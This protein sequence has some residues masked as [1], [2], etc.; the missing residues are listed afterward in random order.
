[1]T[2][3]TP[4][5]RLT[6]RLV[7]AASWLVCR[8]PG[9]AVD[10]VADALGALHHLIAPRPQRAL[11]RANLQ[12]VCTALV[13]DGLASPRVRS[14]ATDPRA[15][16][17]MVRSVYR[18]HARYLAELMRGPTMTAS[19][20]AEHLTLESPEEIDAAYARA[21]AG[22][23][24]LVLG[25][26]LGPV[27][28]PAIYSAARTGRRVVGPMEAIANPPLQAWFTRQRSR[29][30]VD[31]L[32]P[33]ETAGPEL[34]R[35][36]HA[37][38]LVGIVADRDITGSGRPTPFFGAPAPLAAGPALLALES[39]VPTYAASVRRTGWGRYAGRM[40]PLE[41]P[42]TGTRRE[43]MSAFMLGEARVFE[44]L[45]ADAPDQW[46]SLLFPIWPDLTP[47]DAPGDARPVAAGP[48]RWLRP[49]PVSRRTP[50]TS[51]SRTTR[52]TPA[53]TTV[54]PR[55]AWRRRCSR[56]ARREGGPPGSTWTG[57]FPGVRST[58]GDD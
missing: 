37:G 17:R 1:M 46:W 49:P 23:A 25:L 12:R 7:A 57:R 15:L 54:R 28:L 27:E 13:A 33:P 21:A 44:R 32:I 40:V 30:G 2:G 53:A 29:L 31:A 22:S 14:A 52:T 6:A 42:A 20:L 56:V 8:L 55:R 48:G 24:L 43:R 34:R 50:E 38:G 36:L 4:G 11:V 9:S 10:R 5:Q 47:V 26:H 16:E 51:T 41:V 19:W 58:P 18:H 3:G 39:G 35:Q 45:I